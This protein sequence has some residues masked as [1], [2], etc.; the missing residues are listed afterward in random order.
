MRVGFGYDV[1]RLVEGRRLVLG[2][3]EIEHP[4]GLLGH[5]DADVLVHA[6][7]D[8]LLGA[9]SLGDIGTHFPPDDPH[10]RNI[11]SMVL[12]EHTHGLLQKSGYRVVN[13]D[14]T[15]V[16]E[17]PRLKDHIPLMRK[18]IAEKLNTEESSINIKATTEEGM[19][20]TGSGRAI[21]AYAVCLI[22]PAV[23]EV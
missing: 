12:L 6:I 13:V 23:E 11:S 19:G 14:A 8:A 7:I 18:N 4:A 22:E 2:G 10:Y 9:A 20:I 1:H 5:S 3:V 16:C 17:R 15:V 21:S